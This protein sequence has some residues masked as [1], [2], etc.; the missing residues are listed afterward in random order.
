MRKME[1]SCGTL[2]VDAAGRLLLCHVTGT[3]NWDIPKGLRDPGETT[4]AAA[5]RELREETGLVY[6][7]ARFAE[8][9]RYDYRPDKCL[10]LYRLDVGDELPLL[11]GLS[12]QSFFPH[13]ATGKP[14]PEAD[15]FRW[16]T[17]EEVGRLCW[18]RMAKCLL[19]IGW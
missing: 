19:G 12:C 8:L 4:L 1:T 7:A 15:G 11:D 10:H 9:G 5:M 17:A 6:P 3:R 18:P 13:H 16:A 2:V 14:T